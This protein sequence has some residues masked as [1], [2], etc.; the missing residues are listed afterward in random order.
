MRALDQAG[1]IRENECPFASNA[2]RAE[3]WM[4]R[5]ERIVGDLR[6]SLRNSAQQRRFTGVG[7]S[8]ETSVGDDLQF[9]HD[10]ALFARRTG[11]RLTRC[12]V[13]RGNEGVITAAAAAAL[14]D[15]DFV[16]VLLE[17]SQ[18]IRELKGLP[19]GVRERH[20]A[21]IAKS[22]DMN[23]GQPHDRRYAMNAAKIRDSL[24]WRPR[25]TF[26]DGL[27]DTVAWYR[28]NRTWTE[29]VRTGAYREY[30]ERQYA[31]RL[32]TPS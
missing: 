28:D 3:V 18:N 24:G 9:Q 29:G 17:I 4:L 12:A 1:Q 8:N 7:Q 23:A 32:A 15:D 14:G 25:R 26:D 11:L 27:A 22:P 5:R 10:P 16:L 6:M 20:G 21:R 31:A 19:T 30:Y 2:D 13:R